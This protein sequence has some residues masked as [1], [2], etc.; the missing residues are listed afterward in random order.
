MGGFICSSVEDLVRA[1]CVGSDQA[2]SGITANGNLE[3]N[4]KQLQDFGTIECFSML[5]SKAIVGYH[6]YFLPPSIC[7]VFQILN[8]LQCK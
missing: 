6:S 8:A 5:V 4:T 1:R 2:T 3:Y 7:S